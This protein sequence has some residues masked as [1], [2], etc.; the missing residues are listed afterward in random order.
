MDDLIVNRVDEET[1]YVVSNASR[2]ESDMEIIMDAVVGLISWLVFILC[3]QFETVF[4]R[5]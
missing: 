2:K 5:I 4:Y 1:L 3:L